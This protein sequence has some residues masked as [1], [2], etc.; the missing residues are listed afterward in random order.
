M[1]DGERNGRAGSFT[2]TEGGMGADSA[3]GGS[4]PVTPGLR[5]AV[6][7]LALAAAL[8]T[9]MAVHAESYRWVDDAGEVHYSDSLPPEA[10]GR[11]HSRLDRSGRV[12]ETFEATLEKTEAEAADGED[13][14]ERAAARR[15]EILLHTFTNERDLK[16]TR[17][18]WLEA[19]AARIDLAERRVT[20]LESRLAG[21]ADGGSSE[22]RRELERRLA[23][24]RAALESE[25]QRRDEIEARFE[26]DLE[27]FRELH[28]ADSSTH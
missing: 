25:R 28:R 6:V 21:L 13:E 7:A 27:R 16:I 17:D 9:A 5:P 10:R 24:Q 8:A 20:R 2:L 19:A 18:E 14:R 22:R 3:T 11:D 15:D 26:A 23:E 4:T 1:T 12:I